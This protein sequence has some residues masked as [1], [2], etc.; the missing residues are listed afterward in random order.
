[1]VRI[2][3]RDVARGRAVTVPTIRYKL[4]VAVSR[5]LPARFVAAGTLRRRPVAAG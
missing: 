2:A 4:I 3:L 1:M 5:V